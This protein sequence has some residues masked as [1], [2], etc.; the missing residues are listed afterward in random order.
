MPI[1]IQCLYLVLWLYILNWC[2]QALNRNISPKSLKVK[3]M[4]LNFGAQWETSPSHMKRCWWGLCSVRQ[5]S[6]A[7]ATIGVTSGLNTRVTDEPRRD[8]CHGVLSDN[9][10]GLPSWSFPWKH[11]NMNPCL[12]CRCSNPRCH[13]VVPTLTNPRALYP[14][15][16]RAGCMDL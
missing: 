7:A 12:P 8:R 1:N 13:E 16:P 14:H 4:L 11:L 15:L 3:T 10:N 2:K 6:G 9:Q 5:C